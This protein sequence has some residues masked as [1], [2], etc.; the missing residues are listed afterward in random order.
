MK[1][2]ERTI[3]IVEDDP[4]II[5]LLR[6]NIEDGGF[7]TVAMGSG[8]DA[9][10][11]LNENTPLMILL[12]YGLPD[13]N[14]HEFIQQMNARRIPVPPFVL[15]TGQGD[16]RIAVDMMKLG[17]RDYIVKDKNFLD[18]IALVIGRV[19]GDIENEKKLDAVRQ[20]LD[21]SNQFNKQII[22]S[23]QEGIVVYDMHQCILTWNPFMEKLTGLTAAVMKGKNP[24]EVFPFLK[25][26]GLMENI[27]QA[28][29]GETSP[30]IEFAFHFPASGTTGWVSD[31]VSILRNTNHEIIGAISIVHDI[32]K[33]KLW[34]EAL[35]ASEELYRN[36]MHRIPDGVY[37]SS[38]EGRFI[39]LNPAMV[40]MLGYSSK[41]ELMEI[42]IRSQLY[43]E[44]AERDNRIFDGENEVMSV[45]ELK[46]KDG[47]HIW[48]EDHGWYNTD[49]EGNVISYEGVLRD[50]T[51]RKRAQDELLQREIILKKTLEE[52]TGLIE[53]TSE[54]IDYEK[55]CDTILEISGAK[56]GIFNVFDDEGLGSQ[57]HAVSGITEN[58]RQEAASFLGFDV[59]K[60]KWGFNAVLS[61]KVRDHTITRF[62]SLNEL[63]D[64]LIPEAISGA[65]QKKFRLG[66]IYVV[67]ISRNEKSLGDFTIIFSEGENLHNAE[68]V[69]LYANQ[70]GMFIERKRAEEALKEKMDELMRFHNLTIERELTMIEL[71]KEINM[72]L[73]GMGQK[74]KYKIVD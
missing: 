63:T 53:I 74:E 4:G 62:A 69:S 60:K 20:A 34:E 54:K 52:S 50:I 2:P 61:E 25:Q 42:D 15:A 48:M 30:E 57:T 24:S 68:L 40:K 65:I 8:A 71:K 59:V 26:T 67:K 37:K 23:A 73:A 55:I 66:A 32:T 47:S 1:E 5:E 3:L 22:E 18:M 21:E 11:W 70:V 31:A 43:V 72:L 10:D 19:S 36:L 9:I 14:G 28:I 49:E 58:I 35:R 51:D 27:R 41:K 45:I 13:M 29:A 33:R 12:D 46:K 39:D 64:S 16:E 38:P 6:E 56:Y 17:A 44:P 7:S